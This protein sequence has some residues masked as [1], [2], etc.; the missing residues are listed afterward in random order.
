[1]WMTDPK[2]LYFPKNNKWM[3]IQNDLNLKRLELIYFLLF[4]LNKF[5]A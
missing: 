4:E 2:H 1:M 5:V 3:K